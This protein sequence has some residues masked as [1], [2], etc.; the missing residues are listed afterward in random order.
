MGPELWVYIVLMHSIAQGPGMDF[1]REW[2][3]Q[4]GPFLSESGCQQRRERQEPSDRYSQCM[5]LYHAN[6]ITE[7]YNQGAFVLDHRKDESMEK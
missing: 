1:S 3:Q 6:A 4:V 5:L 2:M 7:P